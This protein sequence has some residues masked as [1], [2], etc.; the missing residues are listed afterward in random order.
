MT[1]VDHVKQAAVDARALRKE[2]APQDFIGTLFYLAS[3]DSDM[4]TGKTIV[5]NDGFALH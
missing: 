1:G 4:V 3:A 5:V 2:Q